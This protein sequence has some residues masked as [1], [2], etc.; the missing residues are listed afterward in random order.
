MARP[1]STAFT[2]EVKLSSVKTLSAD[3]SRQ[4]II[5]KWI[6]SQIIVKHWRMPSHLWDR[7]ATD[8]LAA[9]PHFCSALGYFGA[10]QTH[11]HPNPRL[12]QRWCVVDTIAGPEGFKRRENTEIGAERERECTCRKLKL[13]EIAWILVYWYFTLVPCD[14]WP[15][16]KPRFQ[17]GN[18]K[19]NLVPFVQWVAPS[20]ISIRC[21]LS[22]S[23][24]WYEKCILF[25]Y[26]N[27]VSTCV[28]CMCAAV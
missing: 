25:S 4:N 21:L 27:R 24:H 23:I 19:Q 8:P 28:H 10:L 2:M 7:E 1:F 17:C 16:I 26:S 5:T 22:T 13:L 9:T 6:F 15:E 14:F 11:G 3:R 20:L 12:M 18:M